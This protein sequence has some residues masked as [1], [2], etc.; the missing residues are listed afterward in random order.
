MV[1]YP[2]IIGYTSLEI[3]DLLW[4]VVQVQV[5]QSGRSLRAHLQSQVRAFSL[6]VWNLLGIAQDAH[7]FFSFQ[8]SFFVYV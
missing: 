8:N 6:E 7:Q 3:E 1:H 2:T 5:H 4:Q